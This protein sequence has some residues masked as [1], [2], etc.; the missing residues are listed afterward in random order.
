MC[1]G[2]GKASR[3][4]IDRDRRSV[5]IEWPTSSADFQWADIASVGDALCHEVAMIL[6]LPHSST[7]EF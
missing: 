4:N 5:P 7:S 6:R 1:L 2:A 3:L